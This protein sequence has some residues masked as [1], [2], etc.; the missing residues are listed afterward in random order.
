MT[1]T[2]IRGFR[3]RIAPE[4]NRGKRDALAKMHAEWTKI[5]P[6]AFAWL[7]TP[8]LKGGLLPRNPPRSG[9][10]STFPSTLLV[11]SQK[12]L[13][14]VAVEGQA[15]GWAGSLQNRIAKSI[16]RDAILAKSPVLRRE[17]LWINAM[18][19]WLLPQK[20]QAALLASL[21]AKPD[22]LKGI[23]QAASRMMR[24]LV[25]RYIQN[26]RL[27]DPLQ[28]PMQVNQQSSVFG[29]AAATT[30]F[31]A[32]SWLRVSTLERGKRISLPIMANAHAEGR[33]GRLASTF[34][35]IPR[36]G[37]WSIL[38]ARTIE[39]TPWADHKA[40]VLGIDLG[41][42]TLMATSEGDLRGVGF[43]GELLKR[44]AKLMAIQKGL[45]G[46][47]IK[48]LSECRRYRTFV[49]KLDGWLKT[50]LRTAIKGILGLH[51]PRKVVIE[52]LLFAGE[53][54]T[55][56]RRMN[57]LLRRFGQRHFSQGLA[58][59]SEEF[60]FELELVDPAYTSQECR[61]C[62]FVHRGNRSQDRFKCLSCGLSGHAD[63]NAAKNLV[64]RS[65]LATKAS[66][67]ASGGTHG[68][69][70]RSLLRW[71]ELKSLALS[72]R[73]CSGLLAADR[74][75]GDARAGLRALATRSS[76]ARRLSA[77]QL[78]AMLLAADSPRLED[79]LAGLA[80]VAP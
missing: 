79:L 25:R 5:L 78:G 56:S 36:N 26:H 6:L 70:R 21:A 40:D 62:G 28:L 17:L 48:R 39:A 47:G 20:G 45:P 34:S 66:T 1:A 69:W 19:A 44:D 68:Q 59:L 31:W 9:P 12:D 33:G 77:A 51:R 49:A 52:D 55:L 41:L 37:E 32:G 3:H 11:T 24:K 80:A 58:E 14:A 46:A 72:R 73:G 74:V 16:M 76:S 53:Q 15:K 50:T 57:R 4:M 61:G 65:A 54:G 13:M 63:V 22:A 43:M 27:P 2:I 29:K 38:T 30:S 64:R 42:R 35:I 8:F 60:R 10:S 71:A 18:H 23:S 75:V 67:S 7:W